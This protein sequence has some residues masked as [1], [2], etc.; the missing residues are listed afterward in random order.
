M[1]SQTSSSDVLDQSRVGSGTNGAIQR[2]SRRCSPSLSPA[3]AGS[4]H[5]GMRFS[6]GWK[7][8][9]INSRRLTAASGDSS[10]AVGGMRSLAPGF[11][12]GVDRANPNSSPRQGATELVPTAKPLP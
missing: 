6:P 12:P 8:G 1:I 5:G 4:I 7:P 11:Q 3:D 2:C 10:A 9:A